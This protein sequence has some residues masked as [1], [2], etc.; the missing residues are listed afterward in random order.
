MWCT[1]V[2]VGVIL[3]A[4]VVGLFLRGRLSKRY[5]EAVILAL[6]IAAI[7]LGISLFLET[8]NPLVVLISVTVGFF[9]GCLWRLQDRFDRVGDW[10]KEHTRFL[11]KVVPHRKEDNF[12]NAFVTAS[13]VFLVG[14]LA[15]M[16]SFQAGVTGDCTLIFTKCIFD[17]FATLIFAAGM[18]EGVLFSALSVL[19][20]QGAIT[21]LSSL[22]GQV[23]TDAM[24]AELT[25][26]GGVMIMA[27]GINVSGIR[28]IKM[29]DFLP[30]ILVAPIIAYLWGLVF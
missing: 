19:L 22:V 21:L 1:V 23:L 26:V 8:K 12:T 4:G 5:E 25:A 2:N 24:I 30:A 29:G 3:I 10:L 18:G 15:L 6:G 16:G 27:M 7:P 17:F 28:N 13:V 9:L 14:P 11:E 20:F